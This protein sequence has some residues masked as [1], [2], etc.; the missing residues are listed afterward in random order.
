MCVQACYEI[1]KVVIHKTQLQ[2]EFVTL[3]LILMTDLL[4]WQCVYCTNSFVMIWIH[5]YSFAFQVK[6]VKA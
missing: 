6:A 2:R 1:T 5:A 3:K 4:T